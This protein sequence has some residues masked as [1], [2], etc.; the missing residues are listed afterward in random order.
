[1]GQHARRTDQSLYLPLSSSLL[2]P[3]A[4]VIMVVAI[5]YHVAILDVAIVVITMEEENLETLEFKTS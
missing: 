3:S 4:W 2:I 1:V 5:T